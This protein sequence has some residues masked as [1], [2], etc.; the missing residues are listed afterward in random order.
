VRL[1]SLPKPLLFFLLGSVGAL[2]GWGAGEIFA[3]KSPASS[4][5][6]PLVEEVSPGVY[7]RNDAEV[8]SSPSLLF[9]SA[10]QSRLSA[11]GASMSGDIRTA[12]SWETLDDL[13]LHCIDPA[14][15]HIYFGRRRSPTHGELDVD[16]NAGATLRLDPVEHIFWP[17][18]QAPEGKYLFKVQLFTRR[19]NLR[20]IPFKLDVLIGDQ[21]IRRSATVSNVSSSMTSGVVVCEFEYQRASG[22]VRKT[23]ISA[24]LLG[25][26]SVGLT[27]GCLAFGTSFAISVAQRRMLGADSWIPAHFGKVLLLSLCAGIFA[28]LV[29][30]GMLS[31]FSSGNGGLA[32]KMLKVVAWVV[33]GGML[34]FAF[35][36]II[37][38]L[39]RGKAIL[40]G[41]AGGVLAGLVLSFLLAG[42]MTFGR[43]IAC[44]VLG[45]AVGLSVAVVEA[46]AR[47]GYL[48]VIW[49]P[50]EF[51]T[52]NLGAT[53]VIVGTGSES[54]VRIPKSSGFPATIATFTM[55][56]GKA[57]MFHNMTG[58]THPLR[59]GNKLPLG[60]VTI[61][62]KLFS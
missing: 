16:Q 34:G 22:V 38:N 15:A 9:D 6:G 17:T 46:L 33:V 60:T 55:R 40:G 44:L 42:S 50:G 19:S 45:G 29:G 21:V 31:A 20:E 28:G 56:D 62:V 52:V 13:D 54:T 53:P 11:A 30:Q 49:G 47:E 7:R 12:L 26:A 1:L 3:A 39:D 32:D 41:L 8:S 58:A 61:E 51:T 36:L 18:G 24:F 35:S 2:L 25:L 59:D 57:T 5:S 37:P 4:P 27:L 14:G 48:R 43:L 23:S 10:V